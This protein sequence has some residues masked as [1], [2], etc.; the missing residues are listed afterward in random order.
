MVAPLFL[1]GRGSVQLISPRQYIVIPSY[2]VAVPRTTL[3]GTSHYTRNQ[4]PR[5]VEARH[6]GCSDHTIS[7]YDNCDT[8]DLSLPLKDDKRCRKKY[9]KLTGRAGI[10]A[11]HSNVLVQDSSVARRLAEF[12]VKEV[13]TRFWST[14]PCTMTPGEGRSSGAS[15]GKRERVRRK[16]KQD[17]FVRHG[18]AKQVNGV[19]TCSFCLSFGRADASR[20]RGR[21]VT[22]GSVGASRA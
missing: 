14:S 18:V 13:N 7:S 1:C 22:I 2:A 16:N 6:T 19:S 9:S 12:P 21:F 3:R 4:Q 20:P 5:V 8:L 17:L 15:E 11:G 10:L